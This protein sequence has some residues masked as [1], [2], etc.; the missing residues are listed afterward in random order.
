MNIIR[1]GT[2]FL[3]A[4]LTTL[5]QEALAQDAAAVAADKL[6]WFAG[7]WTYNELDGEVSCNML[8]E[9]IVHCDG[10]WVNDAGDE[11]EAVFITRYDAVEDVYRGYRFYS[12]GYADVARGWVDGND[13]TF[14]YEGR[15]GAMIRFSA[16]ASGD[17]WS[18]VWHRSDQGGEWEETS[19]GSMTR[20]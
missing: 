12:G 14:L 11:I 15:D 1:I 13:W 3:V 4:L 19:R 20:K 8:G 16:T 17:S 6:E 7:D 2:V 18:Y 10:A 5:G 9:Y